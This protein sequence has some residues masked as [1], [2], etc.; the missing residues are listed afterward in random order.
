MDEALDRLEAEGT[1]EISAAEA[2][3]IWVRCGGSAWTFA[4]VDHTAA[5]MGKKPKYELV[6]YGKL[7]ISYQ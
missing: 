2:H 5:M 3:A 4:Q 7:R 1:R 6:P